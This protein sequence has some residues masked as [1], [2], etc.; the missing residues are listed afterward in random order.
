MRAG[1]KEGR[2]RRGSPCYQLS[3][4]GIASY[5][6]KRRNCSIWHNTPALGLVPRVRSLD[7]STTEADCETHLLLH[8]ASGHD[9]LPEGVGAEAAD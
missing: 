9:G 2:M 6:R 7:I 1:F 5:V 8:F 3:T 4:K